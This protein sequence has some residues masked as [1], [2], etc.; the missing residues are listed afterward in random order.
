MRENFH[1]EIG[2][3]VQLL[4]SF[5]VS[6]IVTSTLLNSQSASFKPSHCPPCQ[7][8]S[9]RAGGAGTLGASVGHVAAQEDL[10]CQPEMPRPCVLHVLGEQVKFLRDG[11]GG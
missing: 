2:T 10:H 7:V 8:S 3:A 5:Q 1:V 11:S 9:S 6:G 4:L